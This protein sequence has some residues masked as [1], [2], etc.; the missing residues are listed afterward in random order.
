LR[1]RRLIV[2]LDT[3]RITDASSMLFSINISVV[4]DH[5]KDLLNDNASFTRFV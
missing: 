3:P 5:H 2:S 1:N 4:I